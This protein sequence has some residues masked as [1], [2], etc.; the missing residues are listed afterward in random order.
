MIFICGLL[1]NNILGADL[2]AQKTAD[3]SDNFIL[4]VNKFAHKNLYFS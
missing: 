4:W 3:L 2:S 1:K